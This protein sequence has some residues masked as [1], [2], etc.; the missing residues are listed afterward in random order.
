MT[1][2]VSVHLEADVRETPEAEAQSQGAGPAALLHRTAVDAARDVRR[3]RM[4]A[5][6]EAVARHIAKSP[7]AKAFTKFWG[8]PDW[9]GV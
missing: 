6:S 8:K 2:P 9:H 1:S 3:E 5:A 7:D 4:N